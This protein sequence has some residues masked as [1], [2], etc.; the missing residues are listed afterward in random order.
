MAEKLNTL[1]SFKRVISNSNNNNENKK[2]GFN[3]LDELNP[4]ERR[5][6]LK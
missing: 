3:Y 5:W 4:Q 6:V 1:S 2:T